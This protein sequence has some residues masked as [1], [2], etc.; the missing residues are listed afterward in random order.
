MG[1]RGSMQ[2]WDTKL[3]PPCFGSYLEVQDTYSPIVSV[4]KTYSCTC[5]H[6]RALKGLIRGYM[7]MYT[8]D[9]A[10]RGMRR[11]L[12]FR[13]CTVCCQRAAVVIA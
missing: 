1:V 7:Y 13:N 2:G 6:I 12:F 9:Q 4:I 10:Q 11:F 5:N 3:L 8:A